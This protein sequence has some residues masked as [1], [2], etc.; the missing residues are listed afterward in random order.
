MRKNNITGAIPNARRKKAKEEK[1]KV[2][3]TITKK[4]KFILDKQKRL[5]RGKFV[6]GLI[7]GSE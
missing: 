7:E 1:F 6:S 5:E 2:H 3:I 4:A